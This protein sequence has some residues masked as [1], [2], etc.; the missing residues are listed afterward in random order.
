[1]ITYLQSIKIGQ[2]YNLLKK[3]VIVLVSN[4][5]LDSLK[6]LNKTVSK[7]LIKESTNSKIVLTDIMEFYIIELPKLQKYGLEDENIKNRIDTRSNSKFE[8]EL[9][10]F[11][12][13]LT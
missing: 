3:T 13:L 4:Y 11:L 7:W 5:E 6:E 12:K 1:M 8:K 2:Q 9:I 10:I